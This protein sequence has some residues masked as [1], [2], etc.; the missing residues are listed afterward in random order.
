[1]KHD[2]EKIYADRSTKINHFQTTRHAILVFQIGATGVLV[3]EI[4][5]RNTERWIVNDSFG[6]VAVF[7]IALLYIG[8]SAIQ[9][10]IFNRILILSK[11]AMLIEYQIGIN[12]YEWLCYYSGRGNS[13]ITSERLFLIVLGLMPEII[14]VGFFAMLMLINQTYNV[15]FQLINL[16]LAGFAGLL[17]V[18]CY[19]IVTKLRAKDKIDNTGSANTIISSYKVEE[20]QKVAGADLKE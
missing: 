7:L 3:K 2:I 20:G 1:M 12:K 9:W 13:L 18:H 11:K 6:V 8:L 19:S 17:L 15:P 10:N 14:G 16:P 5:Q 4:L